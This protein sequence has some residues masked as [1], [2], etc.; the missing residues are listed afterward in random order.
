LSL[1]YQ[2]LH[3]FRNGMGWKLWDTP[4]NRDRTHKRT[5]PGSHA[6]WAR[7]RSAWWIA[8]GHRPSRSC[9][10]P[11]CSPCPSCQ[12]TSRDQWKDA[13]VL[14]RIADQDQWWRQRSSGRIPEPYESIPLPRARCLKQS[15]R[16]GCC[17]S[18]A[19]SGRFRCRTR[20]CPFWSSTP[21][22]HAWKAHFGIASENFVSHVRNT[23]ERAEIIFPEIS[24]HPWKW[25]RTRIENPANVR[26]EV[27]SRLYAHLSPKLKV[28]LRRTSISN[29]VRKQLRGQIGWSN[30][31]RCV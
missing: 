6:S 15:S 11:G 29:E 13:F 17:S 4:S 28:P 30:T 1:V 5:F 20:S 21:S 12:N 18:R 24:S 26:H 7:H 27:R 10:E 9:R 2:S 19:A 8:A 22:G 14:G 16:S 3:D 23:V 25:E 31:L